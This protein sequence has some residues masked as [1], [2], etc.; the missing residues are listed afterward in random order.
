MDGVARFDALPADG[1]LALLLGGLAIAGL[2]DAMPVVSIQPSSQSGL[3]SPDALAIG[4]VSVGTLC[5]AWRRRIA[6]PVLIISASA[7]FLYQSLSYPHTLLPLAP[8]IAL[9]TVAA[10]SRS[11]VAASATGGLLVGAV[12]ADV[13]RHGWVVSDYD[14]QLFGYL[15]SAG[16]ACMLGYAV[17][18]SRART[19]LLGAQAARLA[20]DYAAHEQHAVQQEQARIARELHDVV[21]HHVS[22]ITA[23]AGAA[24]RVFDAEPDQ[25]RQALRSIELAGRQ[26]LN[27]MRR[28]LGVLRSDA[29]EVAHGPQPG[30]DQL[31]SL[32]AQTAQ[33]GLPVELS[34]HGQPRSLPS[35][36]ELSA[37]RIVQEALT[38]T[39]KHAGPSRASVVVNY[40]SKLLELQICDDGRGFT[41]DLTPGHGLIGMRQRAALLGGRL[42][43]GSG[44]TGGV[45]VEATLPVDGERL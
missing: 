42:M 16:A 1:V 4:L 12:A 22:V 6:L 27:E 25:A 32:V 28:L 40:H 45:K 14:D 18:L 44:P 17:Q 8:L 20:N 13:P 39:L 43:V 11:L 34:I 15:L 41:T 31:P 29:D 38:N 24:H 35:G 33:A 9:Y 2:S 3:Q 37:Y 21:A 36:I 10:T 23:L 19:T 5:L 26:A 30:L 7:F